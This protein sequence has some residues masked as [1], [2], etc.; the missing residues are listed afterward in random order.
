[1]DLYPSSLSDRFYN[2]VEACMEDGRP[3]NNSRQYCYEKCNTK[4]GTNYPKKVP[5]FIGIFS[6]YEKVSIKLAK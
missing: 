6:T 5:N 1:M 2:C 3:Y 4:H